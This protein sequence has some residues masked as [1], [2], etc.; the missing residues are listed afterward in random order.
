[1]IRLVADL[2]KGRDPFS[3][4]K[5][6]WREGA[7]FNPQNCLLLGKAAQN[8]QDYALAREAYEALLTPSRF[9]KPLPSEFLQ[10]VRKRLLQVERAEQAARKK[11]QHQSQSS[12]GNRSNAGPHT[13]QQVSPSAAPRL[14]EEPRQIV[15]EE[16]LP[17][18]EVQFETDSGLLAEAVKR[19]RQSDRARFELAMQAYRHAFRVSYDQ[20]IC[21]PTLRNIQFLT[22]QEETAR[23]VM[24]D[25]RG[26][27]ILADEVGLGKTIEAGLVLKEYIMRG[28]V[29]SALIITPVSLVNQWRE[30][31]QDKFDLAFATSNDPEF[32][33]DPTQFWSRPFIVASLSVARSSRHFDAVASGNYDIVI[34][35]EA[36]H[37]KNQATR[38]WKLVNSLQKTF[39]LLLTATPV[40]NNL[41]ELYNLVTVLRPGHLK[42]RKAFKEEFVTRGNPTDPQNRERLR[43]LLKEVMIRNTRSTSQVH[44]PPRFASVTRIR[45]SEQEEIFYRGVSRLV[46]ELSALRKAGSTTMT[47]R[48]LLEAAGSSHNAALRTLEKMEF[49]LESLEVLRSELVDLGN[50][51]GSGSKIRKVMDLVKSSPDQKIV[52]VNYLATMEMLKEALDNENISYRVFHGGL[53]SAQKKSAIEEFRSGCHVLLS[54]GS[55]GEGHNLQFCHI[56][57]NYD[58]PWNPMEIE[59]RIGRIHRIGQTREVFVHNFCAA[60]TI[61]DQ[62][63]T[64]LDRKINMFELVV[65][66]ID[67]ILGRLQDERDFSDLVF[68]IW[69]KHRDDATR[70]EAFRDLG[71]RLQRAKRAYEKSKDLDEKLFHEDFGV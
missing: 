31:L 48:K 71:A 43:H 27:A 54:T 58:L 10:R 68:E 57:V 13:P 37:L 4:L 32:R 49:A 38:S 36:H 44:M 69:V 25:F 7:E 62:I 45:A 15:A 1:M 59:Q 2:R 3:I 65:G 6:Y 46:T 28:L 8:R 52:F 64:V 14:V 21:L 18:L 22:Y 60:G 63:L 23:K 34:V 35:D 5:K 9:S 39:I 29:R 70:S 47:A 11:S 41:E 67:M 30:E 40:Q 16:N 53:T 20:L 19:R 50:T 61:E 24:K 33:D 55:G 17:P 26:R 66:E 56:M 51:L 12:T 42:T